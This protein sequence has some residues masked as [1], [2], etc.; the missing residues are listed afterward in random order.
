MKRTAS[1]LAAACLLLTA[2]LWASPSAAQGSGEAA[3]PGAAPT[4]DVDKLLSG[5]SDTTD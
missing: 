5:F 2:L 1:M 4:E 3:Q